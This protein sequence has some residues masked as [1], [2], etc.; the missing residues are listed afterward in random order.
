MFQRLFFYLE[1]HE[2]QLIIDLQDKIVYHLH[3]AWSSQLIQSESLNEIRS[4]LIYLNNEHQVMNNI[5]EK[6]FMI[7]IRKQVDWLHQV[8]SL[9]L[10]QVL[11][12]SRLNSSQN[13]WLEYLSQVRRFDLSIQVESEYW[14]W[15]SIWKFQLNSSRHEGKIDR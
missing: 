15:V 13:S 3:A 1:Y 11:N 14:N 12:S 5:K 10:S 6:K 7:K 9:R 4:Y 2:K 8:E